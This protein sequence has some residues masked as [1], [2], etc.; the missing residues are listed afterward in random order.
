MKKYLFVM[1]VTTFVFACVNESS[2]DNIPLDGVSQLNDLHSNYGYTPQGHVQKLTL[3]NGQVVYMDSDSTF[4]LADVTFSREQIEQMDSANNR[5]VAVKSIDRYWQNKVIPYKINSGFTQNQIS[6]INSALATLESVVQLDFQ[7][8]STTS[9]PCIIFTPSSN[10]NNSPLG[11]QANGNTINLY[12]AYFSQTT[13]MH[14]VMH[15]LGFFHEQARTDRDNYVI[16]YEDNIEDGKDHNFKTFQERELLGYNL[17]SFDYNSIMIYSSTDFGINGSVTMTKLDGSLI[18]Q[19]T[20]LSSGDIAG[21]NFIYGP[22]AVLTTTLNSW[23]DRGDD[24]TID[25]S[26]IYSNV[27]TFRDSNN[28]PTS[29]THQRLVVVKFHME[30]QEGP[31]SS[32][33]IS[34]TYTE[35]YVVP[36]GSTQYNLPNTEYTLQEDMGVLRFYQNEWYTVHVL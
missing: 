21:L 17:G 31:D 6:I 22:K 18:S 33:H 1:F 34:S 8:I 35:Y 14:E 19:G 28:Q 9:Y 25:E 16:I 4:F 36:A 12:S 3:A 27:I 32:N 13:V 24:L 23:E 30:R 11:K 26:G 15:S 29:L 5:S 10:A 20:S 7:P 2:L